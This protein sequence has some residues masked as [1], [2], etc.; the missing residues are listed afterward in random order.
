MEESE[1]CISP[2]CRLHV[3]VTVWPDLSKQCQQPASLKK[4]VHL[5]ERLCINES[6]NDFHWDQ[7]G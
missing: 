2:H 5:T 4:S 7:K 6:A 3:S 1:N